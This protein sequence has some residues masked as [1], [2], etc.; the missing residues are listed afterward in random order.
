MVDH[1]TAGAYYVRSSQAARKSYHS[2]SHGRDGKDGRDTTE[3]TALSTTFYEVRL[4]SWSC[5]CPAFTFAAFPAGG[6]GAVYERSTDAWTGLED[7]GDGLIDGDD[8]G[9]GLGEGTRGEE[10]WM[11]GGK[12]CRGDEAPVCKHLLACV[13]GERCEGVFGHFVTEREVSLEE[14]CGWRAGWGG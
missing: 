4:D 14:M 8:A 9:E 12:E 3:A 6:D 10:E 11:F 5:S 7:V 1:Q 2:H 13:L